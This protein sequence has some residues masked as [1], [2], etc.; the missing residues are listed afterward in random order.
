M[1]VRENKK[2]L[3]HTL[4]LKAEQAFRPSARDDMICDRVYFIQNKCA[5]FNVKSYATLFTLTIQHKAALTTCVY[6]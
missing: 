4:G 3:Y 1:I 6:R 2:Y 5:R